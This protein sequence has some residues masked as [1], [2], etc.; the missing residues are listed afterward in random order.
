MSTRPSFFESDLPVFESEVPCLDSDL[1]YL[2]SV[3]LTFPISPSHFSMIRQNVEHQNDGYKKT[4][5]AKFS[6]N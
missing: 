5:Y 2:E 1:P 6:Y 4:K 3:L